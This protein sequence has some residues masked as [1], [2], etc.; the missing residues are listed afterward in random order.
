MATLFW[1]LRRIIE[2]LDWYD[3]TYMSITVLAAGLRDHVRALGLVDLE[4]GVVLG[5]GRGD[6]GDLEL[7]QLVER[8]LDRVLVGLGVDRLGQ[9][10]GIVLLH[11]A[12][13]GL[14]GRAQLELVELVLVDLG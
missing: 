14:I 2:L 9:A 11:Q 1:P 12:H 3:P 4:L 7:A 10:P 8:V 13:L 5:L 6:A